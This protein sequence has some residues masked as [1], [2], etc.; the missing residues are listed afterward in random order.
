MSTDEFRLIPNRDTPMRYIVTS[1]SMLRML[2]AAFTLIAFPTNEV[3]SCA[4]SREIVVIRLALLAPTA[5]LARVLRAGG[6][7][8]LVCTQ[9]SGSR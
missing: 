2:P 9:V 3:M 8:P 6:G 1:V 7:R 5:A 4:T